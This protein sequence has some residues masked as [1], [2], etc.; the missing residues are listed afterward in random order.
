MPFARIANA[1]VDQNQSI[2][3]NVAR[4]LVRRAGTTPQVK[5]L[6]LDT[7]FTAVDPQT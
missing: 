4:S 3:E 7:N 6:A 5:A 2:P 1:W